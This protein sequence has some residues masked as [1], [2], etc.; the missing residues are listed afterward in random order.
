MNSKTLVN[1][2]RCFTLKT[3]DSISDSNGANP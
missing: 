3:A 1:Y 2:R